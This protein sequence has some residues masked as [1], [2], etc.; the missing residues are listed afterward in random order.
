M[1]PHVLVTG[2]T[3]EALRAAIPAV[4]A[5]VYEVL[6]ADHVDE[7]VWREALVALVAASRE[8]V[9]L[10]HGPDEATVACM[11]AAWRSITWGVRRSPEALL[12]LAVHLLELLPHYEGHEVAHDAASSL[13][14]AIIQ[15]MA[16]A[17]LPAFRGEAVRLAAALCGLIHRLSRR[18]DEYCDILRWL[19]ECGA[20]LDPERAQCFDALLAS[21]LD[22][23]WDHFPDLAEL[24]P[25]PAEP[26]DTTDTADP[27]QPL[28]C[29]NVACTTAFH[30]WRTAACTACGRVRYCSQACLEADRPRHRVY[31]KLYCMHDA[32]VAGP[33]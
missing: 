30:H 2:R 12:G 7:A 3:V 22:L 6:H 17:R 33:V 27:M 16:A 26:A 20:G 29:A 11:R 1:Q 9:H 18:V 5:R 24:V 8:A 15:R 25:L 10:Y 14:T 21:A 32:M 28:D 31:C 13:C 19:E 4:L 23:V